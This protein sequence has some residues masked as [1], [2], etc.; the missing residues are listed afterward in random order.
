MMESLMVFASPLPPILSKFAPVRRR[1]PLRPGPV[2]AR[3]RWLFLGRSHAGAPRFLENPSL[4]LCPALRSRPAHRPS[5][6]RSDD[7]VPRQDMLKTP[8][9]EECR[10]S[11]TRLRYPLPTLQ[12]MRYRTRMQG[13][14]P[15]G[16]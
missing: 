3:Y 1:T 7:A 11:I 14:L 8:A 9:H 4:N 10:D 13:S 2:Q 6:F 16:G 15:V 12:V 5:P